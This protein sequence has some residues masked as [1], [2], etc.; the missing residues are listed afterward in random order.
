MNRFV[1]VIKPTDGTSLTGRQW[2]VPVVLAIFLIIVSFHNYLLFHTL[3]E[4]FAIIIAILAA[5]VIWQ[6]YAFSQNHYLM[7]LGCGYFWIAALDMV[8]TLT[9]KG[10]S[11]YPVAGANEATQFWISARYFEALL[12][13]SAPYFSQDW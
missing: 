2:M 6:T 1:A 12:L 9:Y 8:H 3:A 10:M 7:Y 13:L 4:F 11:V 5:V